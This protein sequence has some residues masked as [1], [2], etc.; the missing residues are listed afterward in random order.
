MVEIMID[1]LNRNRIEAAVLV[2]LLAVLAG[3]VTK[4]LGWW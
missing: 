2:T 4:A 3:A 1:W